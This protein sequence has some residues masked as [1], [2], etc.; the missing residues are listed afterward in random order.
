MMSPVKHSLLGVF[1]DNLAQPIHIY[2]AMWMSLQSVTIALMYFSLHCTQ[3]DSMNDVYIYIYVNRSKKHEPSISSIQTI[4]TKSQSWYQIVISYSEYGGMSVF[5]LCIMWM[6]S[7][8]LALPR[9]PSPNPSGW[10][11]S[12]CLRC[13]RQREPCNTQRGARQTNT[14][15]HT[16]NHCW[17]EPRGGILGETTELFATVLKWH[18]NSKPND[19]LLLGMHE[20]G[21]FELSRR[22]P[23]CY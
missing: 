19:K 14:S 18:F 8:D 2:H 20:L 1:W 5:Q 13:K 6:Y 10:N 16:K 3:S 17:S 9:D 4:W 11:E 23:W 15:K 12:R 7:Q 22:C 21:D